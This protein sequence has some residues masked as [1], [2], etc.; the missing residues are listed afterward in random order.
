M[1]LQF[2]DNTHI[3]GPLTPLE[4]A[5]SRRLEAACLGQRKTALG[6]QGQLYEFIDAQPYEQLNSGFF[7]PSL[8][9][10]TW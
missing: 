7:I 5:E 9:L 3:L 2:V 6:P 8:G 4:E 1:P 10:G